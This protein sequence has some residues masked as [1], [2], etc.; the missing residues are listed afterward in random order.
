MLPDDK[1]EIPTPEVARHYTHLKR[2]ADK[3]PALDPSAA[4]LILLGRDIPQAL[5]V[6][7]H[8]NGLHKAPYAQHLDLGWIIVGEVCLGRVHKPEH[9][10]VYRTNVLSN[11][12]TS[13]FDP[14]TNSLHLREKF[15][16]SANCHGPPKVNEMKNL[17]EKRDG[18]GEGVFQRTPDDDK[19]AMSVEDKAFLEIMHKEVFIDDSNSWVAPLP[20]RELRRKLPNNRAQA[21]QCLVTLRHTL[22]K[23]PNMKEHMVAFMQKIFKAG[24]AEP[25]PPL[26]EEQECWYL[27]IFGVY[28]PRKPGQVRAVFDSSAKHN[29]MSLN[30][31]LLSGPDLNNTL[32]G[33]LIRFRKEPVVVAADIEQMFY[34]F[35]VC[36]EHRNFLRFFLV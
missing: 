12:R 8:I 2:V 5:K 26:S 3:I 35:K 30:D 17:F 24:H 19:P 13:L 33:V 10:N 16:T 32:L 6:R 20:F 9:A 15:D 22:E 34:C 36:Q 29:G 21:L 4:I 28:H 7:G 18:L 1:S 11:G 23:K 27:P 31:V 25:A 14:C